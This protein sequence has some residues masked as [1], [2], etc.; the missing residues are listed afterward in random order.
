MT[1]LWLKSFHIVGVVAWF[2]ALFYLV[3]L[4]IYHVE[5]AERP[6]AER[7][8]LEPQFGL[9][10][11]RL[12]RII[13]TPAMWLTV[14]TA[15]GMMLLQPGWFREPWLWA[16][17]ALVA[18]LL[19]Y[20]AWCGRAIAR[21]ATGTFTLSS[22]RLRTLNEVPTLILVV[23]VLLVVFKSQLPLTGLALTILG[24]GLLLAGGI[25]L[26]ARRRR[27]ERRPGAA[28]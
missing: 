26:Y 28:V 3:R 19:A 11:R 7:A 4:F 2:A 17:L 1:Y 21:L 25:R 5:A 18:G 12:H 22:R 20:H 24:L 16:K 15:A 27:A 8:V 13:G 6:A 23:V 9:M 14:L 10:E